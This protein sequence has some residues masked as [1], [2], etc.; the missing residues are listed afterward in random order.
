MTELSSFK[1]AVKVVTIMGRGC[2]RTESVQSARIVANR[3][4]FIVV[5]GRDLLCART[6][7]ERMNEAR[8]LLHLSRNK[9]RFIATKKVANWLV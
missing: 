5:A 6:K 1:V 4:C 9:L 8:K 3:N 2:A 7:K